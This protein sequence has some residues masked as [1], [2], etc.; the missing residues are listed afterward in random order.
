MKS[1]TILVVTILSIATVFISCKCQNTDQLNK[2]LINQYVKYWNTGEFDS[3]EDVLSKD[4]ELRSS[5][6]FEPE[7]GIETFKENILSLRKAYPDFHLAIDEA[8]YSS[9]AAAGRWTI[10]ATNTRS[11][12]NPEA[13]KNI[14]VS[15]MS[16]FHF[17][18]GKIKDEWIANNNYYWLQQLGYTFTAPSSE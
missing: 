17:S 15:G 2:R 13:S 9:N 18:E 8:I 6:K 1:T 5:P 10:T 4:F 12:S 3:I 14:N 16:I 7:V 11:G